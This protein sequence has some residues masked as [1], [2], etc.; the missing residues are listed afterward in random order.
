M[1]ID[2]VW[3]QKAKIGP[4]NPA[5]GIL[6]GSVVAVSTN[7][8]IV[9][10]GVDGHVVPGFA[11]GSAAYVYSTIEHFGTPP[12]AVGRFESKITTLGQVKHATLYQNFPNPFNPE[13]WFPYRLP[14]DAPVRFLIY[15]VQGQLTRELNLGFQKSG[16]YMTKETSA[17]W[18]GRD[19]E[20]EVV[21]SGVYFYT[22]QTGS[23]QATR[24]ML[25]LK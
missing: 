6:F 24:R 5:K 19:K 11:N 12:F 17:H 20:G 2:G 3:Q 8:A 21:A 7:T 25:V 10:G 1:N 9:T 4:E 23:F 22:L 14:I 15:N 16:R 13:T 18:D